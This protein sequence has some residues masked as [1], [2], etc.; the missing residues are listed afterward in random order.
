[1]VWAT[2]L[3]S[4]QPAP[5]L[6][7]T[8]YDEHF[9]QLAAGQTDAQGLLH[10][11]LPSRPDLWTQVYAVSQG[12]GG[13]TG[14]TVGMSQWSSRIDPS[15]FGLNGDYYPRN[16][17]AYLYTDRPI[18]RPGQVVFFKG[19]LRQEDDARYKLPSADPVSVSI[20]NDQGQQVFSDTFKTDA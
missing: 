4:G 9:K 19:V 15:D 13:P 1:V 12:G 18:Y 3:N 11:D 6:P 8:V 2:D 17:A 5:N 7:V 16:P 20:T 10:V 14:F